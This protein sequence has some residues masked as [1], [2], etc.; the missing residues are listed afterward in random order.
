MRTL[1][2]HRRKP[3]YSRK[4]ERY[5]RGNEGP[6]G[7]VF[8]AYVKGKEAWLTRER[9]DEAMQQLKLNYYK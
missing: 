6:D 5:K 7:R 9:F 2:L 3:L 1:F 4:P 8:W